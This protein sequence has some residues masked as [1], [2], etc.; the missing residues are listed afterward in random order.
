MLERAINQNTHYIISANF[1]LK[2]KTIIISSIIC[3]ILRFNSFIFSTEYCKDFRHFKS[4]ASSVLTCSSGVLDDDCKLNKTELNCGLNGVYD[5]NKCDDCIRREANNSELVIELCNSIEFMCKLKKDFPFLHKLVNARK[6]TERF[7]GD[8]WFYDK[9]SFP[10]K[11]RF[12]EIGKF[13]WK[14]T[15]PSE[16]SFPDKERFPEIGVSPSKDKYT[17][18]ERKILTPTTITSMTIFV[19]DVP[20]LV[21]FIIVI[22]IVFMFYECMDDNS[23]FVYRQQ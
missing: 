2:M 7:P 13:P 18:K 22:V 9:E 10:N 8:P 14:E 15:K 4:N 19:D 20:L 23:M 16:E 11:E 12:P 17:E 21:I 3:F 1:D 6:T 5:F